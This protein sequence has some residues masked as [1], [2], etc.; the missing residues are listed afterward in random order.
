METPVSK[1]EKISGEQSAKE[2]ETTYFELFDKKT[3]YYL[4]VYCWYSVLYEYMNLAS[5]I[6]LLNIDIEETKRDRRQENADLSNPSN[7]MSSI[8]SSSSE[9]VDEAQADLYQVEIRAGEK[10]DLKKRVCELM[11]AFLN[12]DEHNKKTL[13]K[14]YSEVSK[15]VRRSKDEEKKTITDYLKNMQKDERKVEDLLKQLHQ[16]RWNVGIQKGVFIYDK[17]TYDNEHT[18]AIL[19]FEQDLALDENAEPVQD[20]IGVDEL[21]R[22]QNAE[23]DELYDNEANDI[24]HFG[25]DYMD[26]NY[27]GED[28]DDDFGYDD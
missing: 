27:Y 26:G 7:S 24:A 20:D 9:E 18:A 1:N 21:E 28:G 2:V 11:I 14:S 3:L 23:N 25:D 13:D 4:H 10:E 8:F 19:R 15:R 6:D 17:S 12:I 5:D 22:E 16:G